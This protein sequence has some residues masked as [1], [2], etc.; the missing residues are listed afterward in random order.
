LAI[1]A[2]VVGSALV[3]A[4]AHAAEKPRHCVVDVTGTRPMACYGSF[5]EAIRQAT[6][7]RV[8][9][10]PESAAAAVRDDAFE[11]KVNAAGAESERAAVAAGS[12]RNAT[13]TR[14]SVQADVIISIEYME[15]DFGGAD[16]IW[17]AN[18]G[19]PDDNLNDVDHEAATIGWAV[20]QITSFKGFSNCWVKHFENPSFGGA[21]VGYHKSR[22]YIGDAMNDR[23]SSLR[24]S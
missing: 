22:A 4:P 10:A 11:A 2:L 9:D 8:T 19:C 6:G 23:T 13:G 16:Q 3:A 12:G 18:K 7:G 21:S 24:W 14:A 1:G 5:R 20:N 15:E 17:V